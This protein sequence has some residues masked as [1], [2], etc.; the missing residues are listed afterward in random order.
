MNVSDGERVT[1]AV[2]GL[3]LVARATPVRS[4][5]VRTLLLFGGLA[6]LYRAWTGR[7]PWYEK[8]G[9]DHRHDASG[10]PGNRGVKIEH[11]IEIHRSPGVLYD[12]WHDLVQLPKVMRHVESVERLSARRSAWKVKGPLGTSLSWDAEIIND[13]AGRLIA[14]QTLPGASVRNAGSVRFEETPGGGTLLKVSFEFD[15]PIGSV[16]AALSA[17]LGRDPQRDLEDDLG[18]FKAFAERELEPFASERR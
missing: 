13:D 7:C 3:A 4:G 5:A 15:P 16:G 2:A 11:S 1:S 6:L 10:V 12:F 8:L 14:W 17:M 9:L 18:Q